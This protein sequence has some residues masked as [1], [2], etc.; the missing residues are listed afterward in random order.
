MLMD[1]V[2]VNT[3]DTTEDMDATDTTAATGSITKDGDT[4]NGIVGI[5]PGK[6]MA[7]Y[8]GICITSENEAFYSHSKSRVVTEAV[9]ILFPPKYIVVDRTILTI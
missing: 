7:T 8:K 9:N 4:I 3:R 2:T 1:E 5:C 6:V